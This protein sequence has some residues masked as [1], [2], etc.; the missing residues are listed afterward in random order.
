MSQPVVRPRLGSDL[1]VG[2]VAVVV[3]LIVG[4]STSVLQTY[5]DR[6]WAS[7]VNAASPWLAPAFLLGLL[8]PRLRAAVVGGLVVCLSELVGYYVTAELRG[9]PA[10]SS[11]LVFWGACAVIGGPIFGGAGW[12]ARHGPERFAGLAAATLPAAFLAEAVMAY[13][14]RLGYDSS[15]VLFGAIGIVLAVVLALRSG[16][17]ARVAAGLVPMFVLGVIAE[18]A[19][20]AVYAQ[21]F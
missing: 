11:L 6:P 4:V 18:L 17:P 10:G 14:I 2:L 12:A 7:L 3:G 16:R 21:S 1:A 15:A 5:L 9:F 20:G 19:L 13:A 8:V